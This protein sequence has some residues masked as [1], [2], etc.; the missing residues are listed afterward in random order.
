MS[1]LVALYVRYDVVPRPLP[2]LVFA[3]FRE[4]RYYGGENWGKKT[5]EGKGRK[6]SFSCGV[7]VTISASGKS[8]RDNWTHRES[9]RVLVSNEHS[10][11]TATLMKNALFRE[12]ATCCSEYSTRDTQDSSTLD[13]TRYIHTYIH[14]YIRILRRFDC[15]GITDIAS[16][17]L[18]IVISIGFSLVPRFLSA[19][20][21][22]K[23]ICI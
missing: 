21:N 4:R 12:Q 9:I 13:Y 6:I 3:A 23:G 7:K 18:N 14:T 15:K 1:F 2:V 22:E 17:L 19:M 11:Y 10:C 16:M 20:Y 5:R 8:R